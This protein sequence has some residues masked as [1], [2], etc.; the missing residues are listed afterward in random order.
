MG[1]VSEL[2]ACTSMTI[3]LRSLLFFVLRSIVVMW[4]LNF[5][6]FRGAVV[7]SKTHVLHEL[8]NPPNFGLTVK[9][10]ARNPSRNR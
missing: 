3:V 10:G 5:P 9:R 7:I 4:D 8:A 2:G 1:N 6:P